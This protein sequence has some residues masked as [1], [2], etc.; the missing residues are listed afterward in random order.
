MATLETSDDEMAA[1]QGLEMF[2]ESEIDRRAADRADN[3]HRLGGEF[4]PGDEAEAR[5]D[6]G[7][8]P[9][10]ERRAVTGEAASGEKA[11]AFGDRAG[12]R[13]AHGEIAAPDRPFAGF[14]AKREDFQAG[15]RPFRLR[16]V[17]AFFACDL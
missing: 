8:Q 5:G 6:L 12:D 7:D 3:R 4:L 13:R 1:R 16:S 10:E 17:L 11:R 9:C 14:A 2:G 15:E